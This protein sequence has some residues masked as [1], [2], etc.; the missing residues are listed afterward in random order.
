MKL[1][2]DKKKDYENMSVDELI[3]EVSKVHKKTKFKARKVTSDENGTIIL[4]P[5]NKND[6]EWYENDEDYDVL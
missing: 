6:R 1:S 4:N 3:K 5:K 2:N